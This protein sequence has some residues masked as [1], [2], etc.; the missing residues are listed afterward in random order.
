LNDLLI[1]NARASFGFNLQVTPTASNVFRWSNPAGGSFGTSSNWQPQQVPEKTASRSDVALFDLDQNYTVSVDSSHTAE[2]LVV[3]AGRVQF[4]GDTLMLAATSDT[5]PSVAVEGIGRLNIVNGHLR[6]VYATI[7]A[8]PPQ[9]PQTVAEVLVSNAG[10]DWITTANLAVGKASKGKL[11]VANGGKVTSGAATI[12]G[13][14]GGEA[15]VGGAGSR[16]DTGNLAVGVGGSA[17]MLNVEAGGLVVSG[18]GVIGQGMGLG[19]RVVVTGRN[20][21]GDVPSSW[22]TSGDLKVG[23]AGSGRLE[24]TAGGQAIPGRDILIAT[25]AAATGTVIVSGVGNAPGISPADQRSFFSTLKNLRVGNGGVGELFVEAGAEASFLGE[26]VIGELTAGS[27]TVRGTGTAGTGLRSSL[28]TENLL[29]VGDLDH[30]RLVIEGGAEVISERG[31]VGS[32][33][34]PTGDSTSGEVFI[35]GAAGGTTP[36]SVWAVTQNLD[37]GI[38]TESAGRITMEGGRLEVVGTLTVGPRGTLLGIGTV[39]AGNRLING[40]IVSPGLSPGTLTIQGNYEQTAA[41]RMIVEAAGMGAGEFD[42]LVVTGNATLGGK[43]VLEFLDGF[44]PRQGDALMFLDVGGTLAGQFAN[45]ELR[46]L[47]PEFQFDLR[48]DGPD[49]SVVALNDGI[50]VPPPPSI[51][52][53][54]ADGDWSNAASWTVD[55]PNDAGSV[56]VFGSKITAPRTV[57]V[58]RLITVGRIDFDSTHSYTLAGSDTIRI[59]TNSFNEQINVISGSHTISAPVVLAD[60]T[61]FTVTPAASNLSITGALTATGRS[62]T[63]AGAGTLTLNNLRAQALAINRGTVAI[64]PNGNA[65]GASV[66]S[67]LTIAGNTDAWTAKLDL[68]NNDAVVHSTAPNKAADFTRLHN[69]VKQGFNNGAWSGQGVASATAAANTNADTGLSVVDNALLG[70]TTFSGQPVTAGSILL[71]YTYYGDIDAN[72]Q[73]DA[74]DLTVFASNFGRA[75]GATQIDGDIDFNGAVDPDDL[76]VFANNFLKGVG[77]PLGVS[78]VN[79][80]AVPEAGTWL[81]AA[82]GLLAIVLVYKRRLTEQAPVGTE[83]AQNGHRPPRGLARWSRV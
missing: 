7:G 25:N 12:G 1:G 15:I 78:A 72:G 58:D 13:V 81:L 74:D 80:H 18:E 44:A 36:A 54:D 29:A 57:N 79:I 49:M 77:N 2:R 33:A 47:A 75:S 43:L 8:A 67:T 69:Q 35:R 51:W 37:V 70:N 19:S 82:C 60:N 45:V 11:F 21:A 64:A 76:T 66:V 32:D 42:E 53:V 40:G 14:F 46:N 38:D 9:N 17:G 30:G 16:W 10:T 83:K 68:A 31:R 20:T 56:A 63:K 34:A 59:N 61:T 71:K 3:R 23:A 4:S 50:F 26:V 6:S 62:I 65:D 22:L 27:V 24:V 41:G 48:R 52:N 55:V 73:V 28:H 5:E 39:N